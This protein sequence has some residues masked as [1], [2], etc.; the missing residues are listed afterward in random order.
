MRMP[1][2]RRFGLYLV[3]AC[4]ATVAVTSAQTPAGS[5]VA[6]A[7]KRGDVATVKALL[8]KGADVNSPEGDGMT[9]LHWAADRG[10]TALA[11]MLLYAGANVS[12]GTRIGQYTPLHLAARTGSVGVVNA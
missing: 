10:D 4:F 5:T 3:A 2:V 9:A 6:D 12:A 8:S 11:Q 7:A 1:I